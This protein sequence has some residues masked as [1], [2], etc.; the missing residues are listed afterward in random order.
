MAA[1]GMAYASRTI[2]PDPLR[3]L[4]AKERRRGL[5]CRLAP[6]GAGTAPASSGRSPGFAREELRLPGSERVGRD[7]RLE[8]LLWRGHR[9][10][11]DARL[12]TIR[13]VLSAQRCV[14]G[15]GRRARSPARPRRP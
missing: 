4:L 9:V 15:H 13:A 7:E 2:V 3:A 11:Y 1:T 14:A 8:R 5:W 10:G 12:W 6:R